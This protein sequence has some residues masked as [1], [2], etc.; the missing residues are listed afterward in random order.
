MRASYMK[1]IVTLVVAGGGMA[2]SLLATNGCTTEPFVAVFDCLPD[3]DPEAGYGGHCFQDGGTVE[4]QSMRC[5]DRGGQC[6]ELG[7][8][9]FTREAV[10]LWMGGDAPPD[11]PER[12][13]SVA[14]EG[15]GDL[16]VDFPC[17]AC[18][19]MPAA[20]ALPAA[21]EVHDSA[22]CSGNVMSYQA[23]EAWDG[24]CISPLVLPSGSFDSIKLSAPVMKGCEP[25]GDPIPM[26]PGLMSDRRSFAGGAYWGK[27]AK[28]CQGVA[29]GRCDSSGDLCLPSTEPPPPE[30]RQCVQYLRD[31]DEAE[32]P[33]CPKAFPD[34]FLFYSGTK[35]ELTCTPCTCGEPEGGNCSA[36]LSA[37][38]DSTCAGVPMPL[39]KDVPASSS[40]CIDFGGVPYPLN[41]IS[42]K[43]VQNEPGTCE[44]KGGELIGEVKGVDPRV[45]CC[46]GPST[47]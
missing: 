32:L 29:E 18:K 27:Y 38:Q 40:L 8:L 34:R 37:Y 17:H 46:Q 22:F 14:Y 9:D 47:Q 12:A 43:W 33:Q 3:A 5:E 36:T 6:V 45:F 41:S 1:G 16:K 24:A 11:C 39:F 15:F 20:C 10:L 13:K 28:A 26:P 2:G 25:I 19:C 21:I 42:S 35:G 30:F 44:V 7:T 31:V 4:P 23:P